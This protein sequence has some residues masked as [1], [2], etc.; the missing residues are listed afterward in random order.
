[1][2]RRIL[3]MAG[4]LVL[5]TAAPAAAQYAGDTGEAQ[6]DDTTVEPGESFEFS[7]AGFASG[8]Q[9]QATL[10]TVVLGT[11]Q[12]N[13][14]GRVAGTAT[15]PESVEPGT[16]TFR[17]TGQD[18]DGGTRVLSATIQVVGEGGA[19]PKTGSSNTGEVVQWAIASIVV[20]AG[21]AWGGTQIRRQRRVK[22]DA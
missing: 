20:G 11:F 3:M 6:V 2:L 15:V 16:Y 22:A 4:A 21:L 7:G 12:A 10:G 1:M 8:S 14:A 13:D 5:L 19:L 17:L 9:V 18:A